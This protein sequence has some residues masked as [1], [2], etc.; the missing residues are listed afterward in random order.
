MDYK[1]TLSELENLVVE[2]YGLW[3]H[4]RVG[5]QWRHYT[6]NHTK[7]VRAMGME[8]GR[9][10]G[11]NI[12]KLEVAGT[13]HDITKRYDGE[14]LN[15]DEGKRVTSSQ[16]FW[17]NEKIK[18]ARRNTV[19][20]LYEQYDLYETVHHDSGAIIT[21]KILVDFGFDAEFVEAVRSI[22]FAHLKPINMTED[23]F[24][25]L[26]KNIENQILYDADTMDP[27]VGY[28]SFFRNI[29][30]HAHFAIQ[31]NGQ[32]ELKSYVEG[33][34]R[35]VD[36]KD[37]FVDQLLTDEA[38]EV[39]ANRQSRTRQLAAEMNQELNN[40][41]INRQYGLLGIIEYFVSEVEDPDFAYQLN[42]LQTEWIPKR[43]KSLA[44]NELLRSERDDA[45]SALDRVIRFT[46]NLES[47]YKGI[48]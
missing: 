2:T 5:F 1:R 20:E 29:H 34:P 18:P 30:I 43:K 45:Q 38:K 15:D 16:G 19:T 26:Y 8:L 31:R 12:Q 23:D 28:T 13:L 46:K 24:D 25:I 7:R 10:A 40:L 35:F 36:S 37:S 33:L 17:L 14:I 32:F 48:I 11:G 22:V 6:W 9:K 27:N 3:D 4:N 21:E 41:E 42:H 44:N 47:E 39:A